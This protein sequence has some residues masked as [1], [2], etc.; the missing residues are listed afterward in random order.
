MIKP[1]MKDAMEVSWTMLSSSSL[2]MVAL[3]VKRTILTKDMIPHV[4]PTGSV[5]VVKHK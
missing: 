5:Y 3:T 1:I 4:T 2:T